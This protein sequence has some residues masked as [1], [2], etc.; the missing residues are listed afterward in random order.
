MDYVDE[1]ISERGDAV[2]A[3]DFIERFL[4]PLINDQGMIGD[5]FRSIASTW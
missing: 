5:G 1:C 4:I 2:G 3:R